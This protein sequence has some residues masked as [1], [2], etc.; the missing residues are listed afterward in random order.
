MN[1][2]TGNTARVQTSVRGAAESPR[3]LGLSVAA[4][5][6]THSPCLLARSPGER[7]VFWTDLW[8]DE[9][10]GEL[11]HL[12]VAPIRVPEFCAA[13]I[14]L[15]SATSQVLVSPIT[16]ELTTSTHRWEDQPQGAVSAAQG[17]TTLDHAAVQRLMDEVASLKK[18]VTRLQGMLAEQSNAAAA[19]AEPVLGEVNAQLVREVRLRLDEVIALNM[20]ELK[21]N[22]DQRL[23]AHVQV[24]SAPPWRANN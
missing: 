6:L 24:R 9:C 19:A 14:V 10:H 16:L 21:E 12:A 18:E 1:P 11:Q 17:P 8:F 13:R 20:V 4:P 7:H 5:I 3:A 15:V 22:L 23:L 2:D